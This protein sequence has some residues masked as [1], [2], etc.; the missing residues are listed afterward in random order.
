[1][2][3]ISGPCLTDA[4]IFDIVGRM[5]AKLKN[6]SSASAELLGRFH[7]INT[8]HFDGFL[9][10]PLLNWNSR[11]RSSAGRFIPGSRKYFKLYRPKIEIASYLRE[12]V[13]SDFLI[14]DTLAHEVIHYWLWVR[15]VPYGHTPEF[16]AK[17]RQMGV[18]RYNTV[19]RLR[20]HK[21]LYKCEVC[22]KTFPTRKRL[23]NLACATCCNVHNAGKY[24]LRFKLVLVEPPKEDSLGS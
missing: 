23:G 24:H 14:T 5:S 19:P 6:L 17:M 3:T 4:V 11:L 10:P 22:E 20:P 2:S 7:E 9:E 18:S 8:K 21:Y 12:E 1:M 13:N 15:R 16:L